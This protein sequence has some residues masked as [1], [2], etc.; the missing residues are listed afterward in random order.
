[1]PNTLHRHRDDEHDEQDRCRLCSFGDIPGM[2]QKLTHASRKDL[3]SWRGGLD[4]G[5]PCE[6]LAYHGYNGLE[7]DVV[8][9]IAAWIK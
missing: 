3:Q 5:D 8:G 1:M 2:M 6:A 4:R 9:A 7:K